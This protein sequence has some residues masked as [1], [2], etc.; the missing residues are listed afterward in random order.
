LIDSLGGEDEAVTWLES[1][2][3]IPE[4]RKVIDYGI[5]DKSMLDALA[6]IVG[7]ARNDT[8]FLSSGLYAVYR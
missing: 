2:R 1:E 4:D 3:D 7:L 6:D 8:G 5:T